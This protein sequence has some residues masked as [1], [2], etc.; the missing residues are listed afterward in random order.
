MYESYYAGQHDSIR[1]L[2]LFH[3]ALGHI[4][5]CF[6]LAL[7]LWY[8][9]PGISEGIKGQSLVLIIHEHLH[10]M[11]WQQSFNMPANQIRFLVIQLGF[12]FKVEVCQ[13]S[14]LK[15]NYLKYDVYNLCKLLLLF[16]PSGHY[17]NQISVSTLISRLKEHYIICFLLF[18]VSVPNWWINIALLLSKILKGATK[19]WKLQ[20][21][22]CQIKCYIYLRESF[23]YLKKLCIFAKNYK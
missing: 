6:C 8:S 18:T 1:D 11:H 22:I 16:L 19:G 4:S 12:H 10:F 5:H 17:Q 20:T 3:S 15:I 23:L 9:W 2:H 14:V 21:I 13:F 7:I